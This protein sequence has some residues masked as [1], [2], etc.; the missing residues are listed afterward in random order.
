MN[1]AQ[2]TLSSVRLLLLNTL[3]K[4]N[5]FFWRIPTLSILLCIFGRPAVRPW[6]RRCLGLCACVRAPVCVFSNLV[7]TVLPTLLTLLGLWRVDTRHLQVKLLFFQKNLE[8][9][10]RVN[11]DTWSF[12]N[13]TFTLIWHVYCTIVSTRFW[14]FFLFVFCFLKPRGH[15][16]SIGCRYNW[17]NQSKLCFGFESYKVPP[18]LEAVKKNTISSWF[19]HLAVW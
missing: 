6:E 19:V 9:K 11:P 2:K 17:A 14:V 13:Q 5:T 16:E 10:I 1:I 18:H 15:V 7:W 8:T 12:R 3:N 4:T